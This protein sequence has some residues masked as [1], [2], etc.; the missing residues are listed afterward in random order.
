MSD[1]SLIPPKA[2][3]WLAQLGITSPD[4]LQQLTAHAV[5]QA[6]QRRRFPV[7]RRL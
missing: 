3:Q 2:R 1:F 5:F 7:N 4:Q 6:L